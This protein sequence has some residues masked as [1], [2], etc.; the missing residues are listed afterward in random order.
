MIAVAYCPN[1]QCC[2]H[3]VD[4]RLRLAAG[5]WWADTDRCPTCDAHLAEQ[6]SDEKVSAAPDNVSDCEREGSRS[7][8]ALADAVADA[9]PHYLPGGMGR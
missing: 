3:A 7:L 6:P 1:V 8:C 2:E 5:R 4:V 9:Q